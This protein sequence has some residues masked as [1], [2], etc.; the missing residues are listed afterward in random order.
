MNRE[1]LLL[2]NPLDHEGGM[3]EFNK[4]LIKT[5]N[6]IQ[7]NYVLRYANIGSRMELF[8]KPIIKKIL[9]PFIYISDILR[10]SVTL[11][12]RKVKIVQVNPSLIP[13][14]LLRD[15]VVVIIAKVIYR[16]RI[17][18]VLHGWKENV[19]INIERKKLYRRILLNVFRKCDTIYV[20]ATDFKE[21]LVC[22]GVDSKRIKITSTFFLE[23]DIK[24][25]P[26][27]SNVESTIKFIY[28]GRISRLKGIDDLINLLTE[29]NKFNPNFNCTLIGH[30]DSTD[31]ISEYKKIVK[32]NDLE[33]KINFV[34]RITGEEKFV[35]LSRA[36]V[37]LF[38]SYTEGCPTAV[39]EALAVG[40]YSITTDVG[41]LKEMINVNNGILV[42]P[43]DIHGFLDAMKKSTVRL[44]SIR[45]N[46]KK[47][48]S[49]AFK[50][51]EV[52][53]VANSFI[54]TY[55]QLTI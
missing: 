38:P 15:S 4:G 41:A 28:L 32:K 34:G 45:I 3:V 24:A 21:K 16:K 43:G 25:I 2:G 33:G 46:R 47:I 22:L 1:V 17:V 37:F 7:K 29:Y 48:S 30:S 26:S 53:S 14:P 27:N 5:L 39:V 11:F 13:I 42:K 36:D 50:K 9:Y 20:L 6:S 8:Y 51:Y 40:L 12:N 19:F 49:D 52:H 23:E 54:E 31:V 35:M 44:D 55:S 18:L 10:I